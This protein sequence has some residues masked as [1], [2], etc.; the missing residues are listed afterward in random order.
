[1]SSCRVILATALVLVT[2]SVSQRIVKRF[3]NSSRVILD[4]L[5]DTHASGSLAFSATCDFHQGRFPRVPTV[6]TPRRSS[7]TVD[8][9]QFMFGG[10]SKIRVTREPSG[11]VRMVETDV[12][13]DILEVKI[14]HISFHAA[15]SGSD[16]I[17]GPRLAMM[18]VFEVPEVKGFMEE[19]DVTTG[20][21]RLEGVYPKLP[22]VPGE[23]NDV[24]VQQ[25]LD[26]ILKAFPGYWAYENCT[27]ADGR[28]SV[29]FDFYSE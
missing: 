27:T 25:A 1:M 8:D 11:I 16:P 23:L 29:N 9:L 24:T 5:N 3:N 6:R 20:V 2:S 14:H 15:P 12:P 22:E 4:V 28:R 7:S 10:N 26:Y 13:T 18:R 19:H 21:F 17:G